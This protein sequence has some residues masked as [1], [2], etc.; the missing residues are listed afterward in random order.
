MILF[1]TMDSKS[2]EQEIG[3]INHSTNTHKK[4]GKYGFIKYFQI[5]LKISLLVTNHL[6]IKYI[7]GI[8]RRFNFIHMNDLTY[9]FSSFHR[10]AAP[11]IPASFPSEA[12][13]TF[14]CFFPK[15]AK[16]FSFIAFWIGSRILPPAPDTPPPKQITSG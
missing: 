1:L 6:R 7:L 10:S 14:V 16:A 5:S 11:I 15:R 9:Y 4:G 12:I 13:L 3:I 2:L 8:I